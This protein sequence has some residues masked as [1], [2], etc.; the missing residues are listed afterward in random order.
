[1][2]YRRPTPSR[3]PAHTSLRIV[4]PPFD[5]AGHKLLVRRQQA[6]DP[7]RVGGHLGIRLCWLW[8]ELGSGKLPVAAAGLAVAAAGL[9]VAAA[10][11]AVAAALVLAAGLAM[12]DVAC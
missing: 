1:M 2:R 7:L 9:A 8:L 6:A 11:L 10:G 12:P 5:S 4:R 3:L